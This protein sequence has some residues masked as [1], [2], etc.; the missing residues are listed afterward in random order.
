[1]EHGTGQLVGV[2]VEAKKQVSGVSAHW[3]GQ[4][5]Y[6]HIMFHSELSV[7]SFN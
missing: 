1:M 7:D 5:L 4:Q 2:A 3:G 6:C